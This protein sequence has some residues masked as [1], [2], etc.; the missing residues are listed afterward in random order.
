MARSRGANDHVSLLQRLSALLSKAVM[1]N[2]L[3]HL[4]QAMGHPDVCS[5]IILSVSGR[6][7][8]DAVN[9]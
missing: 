3:C 9:I 1:V 7:L 8:P 5:D 2:F 6:L 4:D